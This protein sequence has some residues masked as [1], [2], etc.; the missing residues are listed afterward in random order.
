MNVTKSSRLT[1][2]KAVVARGEGRYKGEGSEG[3]KLLGVRQAQGW[4]AQ[5][6]EC[7]Q[8]FVITVNGV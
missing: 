4:S 6:A 3:H 1:E 8:Y 7:R 2:N 5:H